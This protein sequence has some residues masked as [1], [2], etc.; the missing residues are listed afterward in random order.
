MAMLARVLMLG[1]VLLPGQFSVAGETSPATVAP[2]PC[3]DGYRRTGLLRD[4]E[5]GRGWAIFTN[6]AHPEMPQVAVITGADGLDSGA[7]GEIA[8]LQ[9]SGLA[10]S[11]VGSVSARLTHIFPAIS[12]K[13]AETTDPAPRSMRPAESGFGPSAM[14]TAPPTVEAGGRVRV[15]RRDGVV[16][17]DLAG[18]ALDRGSAGAGI[19]VRVSP[20]GVVLRGTV[21]GPAS[22]E[23]DVNARSGFAGEGQ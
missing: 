9:P 1:L 18:V 12:R 7:G 13:D 4:F 8:R 2:S 23:L 22:V 16:S 3:R 19:R 10:A 5:L 20:G 17:I 15:W 11:P 21:R 6:C 14:A